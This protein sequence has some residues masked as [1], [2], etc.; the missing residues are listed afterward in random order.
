VTNKYLQDKD[1]LSKCLEVFKKDDGTWKNE[2]LLRSAIVFFNYCRLS[3]LLDKSS[4]YEMLLPFLVVVLKK[5]SSN[6]TIRKYV[7]GMLDGACSTVN[8]RKIIARS[9]VMEPIAALLTSD[10]I[11]EGMKDRVCTLLHKITS[12]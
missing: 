3:N 10:Y 6:D 5:Y 12:R 7:F 11:N 2:E 9:G 1:I 8:D 4:D